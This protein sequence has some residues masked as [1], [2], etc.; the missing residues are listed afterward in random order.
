MHQ[1]WCQSILRELLQRACDATLVFRKDI[2][3]QYDVKS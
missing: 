2:P 1:L 3:N